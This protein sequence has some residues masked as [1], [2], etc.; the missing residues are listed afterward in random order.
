MGSV[1]ATPGSTEAG[2]PSMVLVGN[3]CC[4]FD[5]WKAKNHGYRTEESCKKK[6]EDDADCIASDIAREKSGKHDCYTFYGSGKNFKLQCGKKANEKCF[7][8][9]ADEQ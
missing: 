6:C 2:A 3:G 1:E 8:K 7:R 5:G 9:S 4:R